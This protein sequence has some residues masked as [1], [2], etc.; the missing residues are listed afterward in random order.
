MAKLFQVTEEKI[1]SIKHSSPK[2]KLLNSD[3]VLEVVSFGAKS[4][5][6]L[7]EETDSSRFTERLVSESKAS[8]L[9]AMDAA[10]GSVKALSLNVLNDG[11]G[12]TDALLKVVAINSILE[13]EADPS[14]ASHSILTLSNRSFG[15]IKT[16]T[17]EKSLANILSEANLVVASTPSAFQ[18]LTDGASISWDYS[19][20]YN[21]KVT[22]AGNRAL[23]EPTNTSDGDYGTLV[24][25][26][27]ATGSRT[28]SLPASFKVVNGGSGAVTL[29]TAANSVDSISWVKN[30]SD[31]LVTLGLNFS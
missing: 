16:P 4:I 29:S 7:L 19:L 23:A 31:F 21:A 12:D 22:L 6:R 1:G 28:L 27:D 25:T 3:F 8:V 24:V 14:N 18:T 2:T 17:V 10:Q 15:P 9:T 5:I 11:A 13:A 20:G 30:G 26:Q